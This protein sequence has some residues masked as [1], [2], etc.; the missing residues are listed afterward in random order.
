MCSIGGWISNRP[1]PELDAYHLTRALL[2]Y[3]ASRGAQSSGVYANGEIVKRA[4]APAKLID[5]PEFGKLFDRPITSALT[6]TR[7]PT[8]GGLG[9]SQAQPFHVGQTITVHNGM[10][11]DPAGIRRHWGL[12]KPSGVDS[13]LVA[14][15]IHRHNVAMLP[16][17]ID[18]TDGPS[19]IAA[20]NKGELY[21]FRSGNPICT[22]QIDL[23]GGLKLFTFA[24]EGA[25]LFSA[26]KHVW[27]VPNSIHGKS[28]KEGYL[29]HASPD[30]LTQLSDT[31][32]K[33]EFDL[34]PYTGYSPWDWDN[35]KQTWKEPTGSRS[36]RTHSRLR[37]GAKERDES[38]AWRDWCRE[39]KIND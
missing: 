11:F 36:S 20:L 25:Q 1:L 24:S 19:A 8:S 21:L 27:L 35:E 14:S 15:F 18:T 32:A 34:S 6:H 13:E 17:F 9:D 33:H 26:L 37:L 23:S 38:E 31:Q 2:Y 10:Y 16:D 3:G 22:A 39:R 29:F 4:L 5:L 30:G 28:L 7:Q 12:K